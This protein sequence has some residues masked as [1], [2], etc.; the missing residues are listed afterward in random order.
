MSKKK[1][2]IKYYYDKGYYTVRHIQIYCR[3]GVISPE[4]YELIT[5]IEYVI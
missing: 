2:K 4:E 3:K 1:K 5:G